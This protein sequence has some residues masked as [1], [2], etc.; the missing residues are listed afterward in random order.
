MTGLRPY[1][2]QPEVEWAMLNLLS[3]STPLT[4]QKV[5]LA[6]ADQFQLTTEQKSRILE[7]EKRENA[8]HNLC[9][10]ARR[11]LV[12]QKYL[13][14]APRGLWS[15]TSLGKDATRSRGGAY[16]STTLTPEQLG[17]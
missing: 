6:L 12:D 3:P 11:R 10:F 1:P 16:Q 2:S 4:P 5:Y 8:W 9:R 13:Y 14:D 17:L 15:I 7:G